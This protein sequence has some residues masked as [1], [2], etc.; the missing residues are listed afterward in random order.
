MKTFYLN[1]KLRQFSF[2][3]E[4]INL[5][6]N[7]KEKFIINSSSVEKPIK[8]KDFLIYIDSARFKNKE[9]ESLN[10]YIIKKQGI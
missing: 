10:G 1:I 4:N 9:L 8:Y 2:K 6:I 5:I 7:E 3:L